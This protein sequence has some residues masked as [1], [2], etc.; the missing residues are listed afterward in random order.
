MCDV[1]LDKS[2][3]IRVYDVVAK[4]YNVKREKYRSYFLLLI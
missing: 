2:V 1:R 4:K 3:C